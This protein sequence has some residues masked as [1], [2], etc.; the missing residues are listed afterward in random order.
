MKNALLIIALFVATLQMSAQNEEDEYRRSSIYSVLV[1][2]SDLKYANE[3]VSVFKQIPVPDKYNDH[4]LSVKVVKATTAGHIDKSIAEQFLNNNH[5]ASRLVAKWFDWNF[6][7]GECDIRIIA[8]RGLYDA[9]EQKIV[10]AAASIRKFAMLEDA[11]Q[12]LI[13]NTFVLVNDIQ[14]IDKEQRAQF[15][16]GV[17]ALA[18]NVMA[19]AT[20]EKTW[21]TVGTTTAL[22]VSTIKGFR[23][24]VLTHLYQLVWDKAAENTFY[25]KIYSNKPDNQKLAA[26]EQYRNSFTL[27]YIGSQMSSGGQTSF[28]GINEDQPQVMIR[29]ACQ[30]A[31]DENVMNLQKNFDVFKVK[32]RLT[33]TEPITAPIGRK[34][35]IT[36]NSKFE[37]LEKIYDVKKGRTTY[38]RVGVIRPTSDDLI[39]D[40]RYMSVEER[41]KG[42]TLG[43][44]TFEKVSGGKFNETMLIREIK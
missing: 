11:G 12:E 33:S 5:V 40:N 7:T 16:A 31:L 22:A 36:T 6:L 21:A 14:Y 4:D 24:K 43:Y 1:N 26:M 23:V 13:G 2:H 42:A 8:K 35:G 37:V 34:E 38:K 19:E 27:R 39:W 17:A 3:I 28:L 10:E 15:W 32:V 29:K 18:G 30:R 25:E 44:T 20:G 9:S 41:A